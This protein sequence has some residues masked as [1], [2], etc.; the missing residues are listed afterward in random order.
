MKTAA[1]IIFLFLIIWAISLVSTTSIF[2]QDDADSLDVSP[3]PSVTG[4]K[5][6]FTFNNC[7]AQDASGTF[8]PGLNVL[9]HWIRVTG[10]PEGETENITPDGSGTAVFDEKSDFSE[11]TYNLKAT[12]YGENSTFISS[13]ATR[14]FV[15]FAEERDG[16]TASIAV[17]VGGDE[18]PDGNIL[19]NSPFTVKATFKADSDWEK[20]SKDWSRDDRVCYGI[21]IIPITAEGVEAH[22]IH[23][24]RPN[25]TTACEIADGINFGKYGD[26]AEDKFQTELLASG[27]SDYNNH[28]ELFNYIEVL[29]NDSHIYTYDIP[30]DLITLQTGY[31]RIELLVDQKFGKSKRRIRIGGSDPIDF[32]PLRRLAT[33]FIKVGDPDLLFSPPSATCLYGVSKDGITVDLRDALSSDPNIALDENYVREQQKTIVRCTGVATPFGMLSTEPS[34]LVSDVLGYLLSISGMIALLLIIRSGYQIMTSSGN[35][36]A[37]QE[38]RERLTSAIVGLLFIIFSLVILQVVGVDILHIPEFK[39]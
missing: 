27:E 7:G 10:N 2:A 38:A 25:N 14:F 29:P 8:K 16:T 39:P 21:S 12:C 37:I 23:P 4:T 17:I 13:E 18:V 34:G 28:P 19:E 20:G 6:T 26:N 30:D 5:V 35:P 33:F 1:R 11:G 24:P 3:N 9:F 31:Y 15:S 36:E 22:P 32:S